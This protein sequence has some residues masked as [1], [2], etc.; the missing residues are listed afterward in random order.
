[1]NQPGEIVKSLALTATPYTTSPLNIRNIMDIVAPGIPGVSDLPRDAFKLT[2]G[3]KIE[4]YTHGYSTE[5]VVKEWDRTKLPLLGKKHENWTHIAMKSDPEI[6]RQ[7][8]VSMPK[9]IVYEL[10]DRDQEIY[11]W[12]EKRAQEKYNPDNPHA[13]MAHINTLRMICNTVE[14]LK[15]GD[16]AFAREIIEQFGDEL[17]VESSSKYQLVSSMLET[18]F[19]ADQKAVL[20][21]FWTN[22]TL[23]PYL[24][25]LKRDFGKDALI[26]PI[27]GVGM[28][29][30]TANDHIRQFN[31]SKRP[32]VL[33]TSDVLQEGANLYAP[34]LWN[35]EIPT[36]YSAYKQRK[37][38]INRADS[39]SKGV[40]HTWVYRPVASGTVEE[41]IDAK[42]I[43]RRNEAEAIRG[44]VDED[45]DM[46]DTISITPE[47][48][49]FG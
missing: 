25:Q 17:S 30:E 1:M 2:Y 18:Y 27:W 33:I 19:E 23:F 6:A 36:T 38:R 8:P 24:E 47:G 43:N 26:L 22:G 16:S 12:A 20:F 11:N 15:T 35:L 3:K 34:Y 40:E 7:F 13:S 29:S 5:L 14:G 49:L 32:T 46:D 9:R 31:E 28:S 39:R 45:V 44:V 48:L 4:R 42:V 37:D 21:T 10:S 41:R